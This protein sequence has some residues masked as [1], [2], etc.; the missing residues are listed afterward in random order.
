MVDLDIT[1]KCGRCGGT[2][3][4]DNKKDEQ[5]NPIEESCESCGG[6]GYIETGKINITALMNEINDTKN[7]VNDIK[8]KVDETKTVADAIKSKVD[9]L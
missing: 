2:G 3:T 1:V 4:D 7:K 8:E 5:G 9:T 6:D